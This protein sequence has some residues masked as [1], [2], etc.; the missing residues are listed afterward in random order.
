M[1]AKQI[2]C[3]VCNKMVEV[4]IEEGASAVIPPLIGG[5]A[6]GAIG[7]ARGHWGHALVGAVLGVVA[8]AVVQ[9]FIPKAQRIVCGECGTNLA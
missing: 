6:G 2:W 8:G 4:A 1:N 7:K 3:A 9:A 5:T